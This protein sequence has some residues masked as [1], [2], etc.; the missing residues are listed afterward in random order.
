MILGRRLT[1][2]ELAR[3]DLDHQRSEAC[4]REAN[5]Q[6]RGG[7]HGNDRGGG[8]WQFFGKEGE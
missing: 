7:L 4:L 8:G 6:M 5:V 2:S 1:K 3:G